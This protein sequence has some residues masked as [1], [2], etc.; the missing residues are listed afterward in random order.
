MSGS[1]FGGGYDRPP[2]SEAERQ[3]RAIRNEYPDP[4]Q[5]MQ[6]ISERLGHGDVVLESTVSGA[7][8]FASCRCG[9]VTTT[10]NTEADALGGVIHHI[11]KTIKEWHATGLPLPKERPAA[12]RPEHLMEKKYAHYAAKRE[13][14]R[15]QRAQQ[16]E[17]DTG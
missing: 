12:G 8:W 3:A 7:R 15:R 6:V 16:R 1:A 5:A 4:R 13:Q 9:Y 11:K 2:A 10:C 14:E 17:R